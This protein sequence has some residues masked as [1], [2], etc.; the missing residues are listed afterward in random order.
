VEPLA[1]RVQDAD[2]QL[3][4][5]AVKHG[6][7]LGR[8]YE[9]PED[10]TRF[11]FQRDRGRIVHTRAFR[12]LKGKTQVFVGG[13]GDHYRT[14]LTHTME[15]AGISRDLA[16]A[17]R[18][19]EDLAECIALAHDLGH[20][21]FGHAGEAALDT[22]LRQFKQEFEH[23]RQSH[24]IVTL[25]ETHSSQYQGLN[26]NREVLDGLLKHRP[27]HGQSLEAQIVNIADEIAYV[28]H[29]CE[30]GQRAGLFKADEI[31]TVP[32]VNDAAAAAAARGTS[33]R[34]SLIHL[35][36]NDLYAS[37]DSSLTKSRIQMLDDV[38]ASAKPLVFF[39]PQTATALSKLRAFLEERMYEHP[40]VVE[41]AQ[42]GQTVV[43]AL[44]EYL[45]QQPDEAVEALRQA[46]GGTVEE[47]VKDYV[48]GM[49]DQ[50]AIR[51]AQ[52]AG[53]LAEETG[54]LVD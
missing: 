43:R 46:N 33:L 13:R 30:D 14:R 11:R 32:L 3:A 12:R 7:G 8:T 2:A 1:A 34:G 10:D 27:Q 45:H 36:V 51:Q 35:L 17:L 52:N 16:R 26:L 47:A 24:R 5:Y 4:P 38:Y 19:N 48:A 25:L 21:P 39:S 37:V 54:V 41:R 22:W 20:P 40:A 9:E 42:A 29:D 50:Y 44:C 15:V 49:T 18:L 53:V 23:N 28:S 6:S 31:L